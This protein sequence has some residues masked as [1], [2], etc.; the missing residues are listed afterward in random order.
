MARFY[1]TEGALH[2]C[3]NLGFMMGSGLAKASFRLLP[4][5]MDLL[6]IL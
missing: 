5:I 2:S 3:G 6:L 1:A 4:Q